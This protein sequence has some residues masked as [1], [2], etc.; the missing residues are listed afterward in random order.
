MAR[1]QLAPAFQAHALGALSFV[2]VLASVP[3]SVWAGARGLPVAETLA[4]VRPARIGVWFVCIALAHWLARAAW[5]VV[6]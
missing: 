5:H 2:L 4:R 3:L 1:A 6:H